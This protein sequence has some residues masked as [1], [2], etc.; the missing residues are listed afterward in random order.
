MTTRILPKPLLPVLLSAQ[1]APT[2]I[3]SAIIV[4]NSLESGSGVTNPGGLSGLSINRGS[5][6]SA[7]F[8]WNETTQSFQAGTVGALQA[9]GLVANGSSGVL[10]WNGQTFSNGSVYLNT[11]N[12]N[13]ATTASPT[14]QDLSLAGAI[15]VGNVHYY[16]P[17]T[18]GTTN[19]VLK[20]NGAGVLSWATQTGGGG[21]GGGNA[22]MNTSGATSIVMNDNDSV[23]VTVANR[24]AL[25][26]TAAG[27]TFSCATNLAPTLITSV[28]YAV[29]ANDNFIVYTGSADSTITLPSSHSNSGRQLVIE[30]I[31]LFALTVAVAM[32]DTIEGNSSSEVLD[33]AFSSISVMSDGQGNW[34]IL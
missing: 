28:S 31:T 26:V 12:Q 7:E 2:Q 3:S 32:G 30:N 8:V 20:T 17:A 21:S 18:D 15:I 10:T 33:T 16:L 6:A 11:L 1:T 19:Q 24:A 22:I 23:S 34:V 29:A 4:A 27:T 25:T 13:V 9:V 5:A 14:F